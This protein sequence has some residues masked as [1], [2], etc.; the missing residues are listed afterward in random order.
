MQLEGVQVGMMLLW[1]LPEA[2]EKYLACASQV[3]LQ[4]QYPQLFQVI[5]TSQNTGGEPAGSF[6]LPAPSG[7]YT[8]IIRYTA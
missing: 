3:L 2:P 8:L 1:P 4:K 6:R 7:S 5:G